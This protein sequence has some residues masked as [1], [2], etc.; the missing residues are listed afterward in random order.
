MS[1]QSKIIF[2]ILIFLTSFTSYAFANNS[3][4]TLIKNQYPELVKNPYL[5]FSFGLNLKTSTDDEKQKI[6][7]DLMMATSLKNINL[8]TISANA[9]TVILDNKHDDFFIK[10]IKLESI[11]CLNEILEKNPSIELKIDTILSNIKLLEKQN[12]NIQKMI[13]YLTT[14]I[15]NEGKNLKTETLKSLYEFSLESNY[16]GL[17]TKILI[18]SFFKN[19]DATIKYANLFFSLNDKDKT[20]Q[21][22]E[23]HLLMLLARSYYKK[24]NYKEALKTYKKISTSSNL[25]PLSLQELSW[26]ALQAKDYAQTIG[27]TISLQSGVLKNTFTPEALMVQAI[28]LHELCHY[29]DA[30]NSLKILNQKYS[31]VFEWL[32]TWNENKAK[33]NLYELALQSIK[34]T[35]QTVP[36]IILSEWIKSETF[37]SLQEQINVL[38]LMKLKIKNLNK[39]RIQTQL[40]KI[41]EIKKLIHILL[42]KNEVSDEEMKKLDSLLMSYKNFKTA[43]KILKQSFYFQEKIAQ[44]LIIKFKDKIN[45]DFERINLKMLG[46]LEDVFDNSHFIQ[47]EIFEEASTDI[48][49]TN[50]NPELKN[51]KTTKENQNQNHKDNSAFYDWGALKNGL[52]GNDEIWEDEI[53]SLQANLKSKCKED[54]L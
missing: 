49:L 34:K 54:V 7:A 28:A 30:L 44:N 40:S 32:K 48:T 45:K 50:L 25:L 39:N 8:D 29:S 21:R 9:F 15:L 1:K 17:A 26:A 19:Y 53:S 23:D 18:S 37:L 16:H 47:A 10:E 33:Y 46:S 14:F 36:K 22:L 6:L 38:S 20:L 5:L 3:C 27:A 43:M 2:T 35:N 4:G 31:I 13:F 24:E 42:S 41:G 12:P 52:N 51:K 11:I